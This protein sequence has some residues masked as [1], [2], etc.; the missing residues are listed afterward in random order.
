MW[1]DLERICVDLS[2]LPFRRPEP[3]PQNS[4][5]AARVALVGLGAIRGAKSFASR[6]SAREFGEGRRID[7]AETMRR[8]S[9]RA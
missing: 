8:H 4:V 9:F 6:F 2:V 1:R 5:L 3:F 7:D